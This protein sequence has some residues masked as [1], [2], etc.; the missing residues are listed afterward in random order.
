M[1]KDTNFMWDIDIEGI[2][3]KMSGL[4]DYVSQISFSSSM[5]RKAL[6]ALMD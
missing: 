3:F 2:S 4:A 6:D 5:E 1:Q